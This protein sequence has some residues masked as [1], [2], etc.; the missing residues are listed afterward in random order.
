MATFYHYFRENM[1]SL[2]LPAPESLF[3]TLQMALST[4]ATLIG[5]IDKFGK[6]VT[7]RELIGA[8]LR[9]EKLS[10]IATLSGAFYAGA[11]I[12]SIAVA[13]GRSLSGGTSLADVMWDLRCRGLKRNWLAEIIRRH[14]AIYDKTVAGRSAY[15]SRMK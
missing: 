6:H 12:G 4:S 13:S 1:Q 9:I 3:G 11:V 5:H 10:M 14:P 8:G 15:R 7:I 2:G